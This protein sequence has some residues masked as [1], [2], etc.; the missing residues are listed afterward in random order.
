MKTDGRTG[1]NA[2]KYTAIIMIIGIIMTFYTGLQAL[3]EPTSTYNESGSEGPAA[4]SGER[5]N[6]ATTTNPFLMPGNTWVTPVA[7]YGQDVVVVL[8][9]VNMFKY[10]IKDIIITPRLGA[11]TDDFPFEIN[12][13]GYTQK[14]A[15]LLGEDAQ[16]N[17]S[18]RLYNC[19]WVFKT[20][21][22]VKTGYYKLD[23]DITYTDPTCAVD[24]TVISVYVKTVGLPENGTTDGVDPDKKISTPRI[25]V[26]GFTTEPEEVYS[27]N[28]FTL[29]VVIENTSKDTTVKNLQ[30]DLTATVEGSQTQASYAAFLPTSGSN[31]FYIDSVSPGGLEDLTMDFEAKAGLEQKP[32]VMTIDMKYEDEKAN[33]YEGKATFSIPV[34][35][36]SKFDTST[37]EIEPSMIAVGDQS[38]L[39]FAIYNTGKTTLYN[40][41]VNVTDPSV[42]PALAYVGNLAPGATG[43]VDLMLTGAALSTDPEGNIPIEISYEDESGA[44]FTKSRN[45]N[46]VV[47]EMATEEDF[48]PQEDIMPEPEGMP[49]WQKILIGVGIG[50]AVL[51][52]IILIIRNIR[53]KKRLKAEEE[54]AMSLLEDDM[55]E[56]SV[57]SAANKSKSSG[58]K[59]SAAPEQSKPS[60]NKGTVSVTTENS[61][62]SNNKGTVS[63]EE[64]KA[65]SNKASAAPEKSKP[66]DNEE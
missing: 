25:I 8:P 24:T 48:A 2:V 50:L 39:I 20:R 15:T 12:N 53:K 4:A 28:Q 33:P 36:V 11:K 13:T 63:A 44:T 5:Y 60:N 3:A 38:N 18:Q 35:Q 64:S 46:L 30:M 49:I 42:N 66:S 14:I 43:N 65:S 10:N 32:Y 34:K 23:F 61:K 17:Y 21:E 55:I 29:N 9:I 41:Q 62:N 27:G 59:A 52:I 51:I 6:S 1:F 45:I 7:T 37:P 19:V 54:L 26:K 58:N 57:P 16:P 22:N 56:E 40:V 47:E 31:S